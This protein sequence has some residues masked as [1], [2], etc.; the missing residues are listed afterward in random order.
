MDQVLV[1]DSR[2]AERPVGAKSDSAKLPLRTVLVYGLPAI[3]LSLPNILLG[4]YFFKFATDVLFVAPGVLG[5]LVGFSRIWDA[6]SDP[7]A[8]YY[9][10]RTRSPMGRRR[11]WMLVGG[12]GLAISIVLL[13]A[14]PADL[15]GLSITVWVGVGLLLTTTAA[16]VFGV[17]YG[18]LGVELTTD[19]HDRTRVFAYRSVIGGLGMVLGLGA[20]YL[21]MEA[22]KPDESWLGLASRDVALGVAILGSTLALCSILTLVAFIRERADYQTRGPERIFQAFYDVFSNRH[23][24]QLLFVFTVQTFGTA[25]MGLLTAYLFQ[26]ILKAPNWMAVV[27]IGS[28]AIPMAI[29]IP[30]WVRISRRFGKAR[31]YTATLWALGVLYCLLYFG[32]RPWGFEDHPMLVAVAIFLAGVLGVV[33]ACGIIVAPSIK[34]DVIDYDEYRTNERKEGAYLAAWSFVQKSAAGLAAML[35]G[36]VLQLAGYTPGE[37]QSSETQFAIRALISFVPGGAFLVAAVVF[38]RFKL[39]EAEHARIRTE[40]DA[41]ALAEPEQ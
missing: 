27:F 13:W 14:P 6:V 2:E 29:S 1:G 12:F 41:R 19:H 40:L 30:M 32:L 21:L 5:L 35:L 3:G 9:S 37:E 36:A 25:S 16:T 20:F 24:Q 34:A 23:A 4:I 38:R 18:A 33:S 8:G 22:E 31:S 7:V 17:P 28:F 26:Y 15:S 11:P 39:D 10:D